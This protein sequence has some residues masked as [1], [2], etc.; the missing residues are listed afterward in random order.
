M[1]LLRGNGG[2]GWRERTYG[3][4]AGR[5]RSTRRLDLAYSVEMRLNVF[6]VDV[7]Q[8]RGEGKEGKE[9]RDFDDISIY[10]GRECQCEC[11]GVLIDEHQKP[12]EVI[13]M[14]CDAA[15]GN[16]YCSCSEWELKLGREAE[17]KTTDKGFPLL[18]RRKV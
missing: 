1:V 6:V 18:E 7:A 3:L 15:V 13:S 9:G 14:R 10:A 12:R 8:Q 11:D 16:L 5:V 2:C 4:M 17:R